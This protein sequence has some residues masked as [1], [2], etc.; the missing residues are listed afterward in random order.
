MVGVGEVMDQLIVIR[1]QDILGNLES[2]IQILP[3]RY[4]EPKANKYKKRTIFL[5]LTIV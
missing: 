3:E 4:L 5:E 2:I 1:L